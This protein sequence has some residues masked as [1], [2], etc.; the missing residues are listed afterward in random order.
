MV[1]N[2]WN[3][4]EAAEGVAAAGPN[5]ADQAVALEAYASRLIGSVPEL[6]QHGGG[7]TSCKVT[8]PDL[9]G[10]DRAVL[11]VKGSGF[12]LGRMVPRG[13]PGLW[14]EP[15]LELRALDT[16]SDEAMVN[17]QRAAM[18][19]A[20]GPTPSVET[21]LHAFLPHRFINHTHATAMLALVN[22]PDAEDAAR[23]V[24]GDRLAV[25]PFVMP[26]F[27]LAK[28]AA[29]IYEANP[30]VEGL[31]LLNHGHFAF[32][33]DAWEAYERVIEHTNLAED[34]LQMKSGRAPLRP[35]APDRDKAENAADLLPLLRGIIGSSRA[36][37]TGNEDMPMPVADLRAGENVQAFFRRPDVAALA[38][39]GVATPDHVIR[40]K[41]TPLHLTRD[42][43]A[44]G[45]PAIAAAV[46]DYTNR[47]RA[48]FTDNA[49]RFPDAKTML[50]PTPDLLWV[51]GL[52]I[53][54]LGANAAA[55]AIAADLAEQ[56][57]RAMADGEDCGGFRPLGER[58]VFDME[59]WSL[60][61][62]KLGK[63]T[64]PPMTGRIV[65]ITGGAGAIGL[66]TARAFA[67]A[68][69]AIFLVDRQQDALV[70]ALERLGKGHDGLALDIT[71]P[72]AAERA[73]NAC[74]AR[75]GGLDILISNAGAAWSG[76]MATL[77]KGVLRESFE[78]NFFAHNAFAQEAARVFERQGRGGQM[79]FNLS[80]QAVNPGR[81]FGAYG[82][83]KAAT[84]FLTRQLA[85]ELGP[86]GVRVNGVNADRIRSGLLDDAF[87][88]ERA[89]ARGVDEASYMAGNLLGRE[90]EA[91]HVAA[92]FLALAQAER[93][94]GHV[95]TVDGGNIEAALR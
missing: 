52:G 14:L 79:L 15:L 43:L 2:I 75:F 53:V 60:E 78:L 76:D 16:L 88:A 84:L 69:A 95:M 10:R 93:T 59:Y 66:A 21:L 61:Q 80:K 3:E 20:S 89:R 71:A 90:V 18:L 38:T 22:L 8:R 27:A 57:L 13:L 58:E 44:A 12:D 50:N 83:P 64:P 85:L 73:V 47:Y 70:H 55:A 87:I 42:T 17:A 49:A 86:K 67:E 72:D 25:V 68:G 54:G 1:A 6:V 36:G 46:D 23:E 77:D 62:A 32:A 94:T 37:F 92:A 81:S 24:F 33:D 29:G 5:A 31:L 39:R 63:G 41:N 56:N 19:D 65:L 4:A 82:L 30:A 26:G 9:F 45:R 34:W 7:N 74:A 40:I 48:Y 51:E 91:H 11:H 35:A 28:L